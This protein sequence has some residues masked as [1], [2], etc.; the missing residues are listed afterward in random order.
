[1]CMLR[2]YAVYTQD[3]HFAT[4]LKRVTAAG[5][6]YEVHVARTRFWVDD[7]HPLH[8]WIALRCPCVDGETDHALGR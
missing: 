2:Q 1:M 5:F 4:V 3:P 8:S 6:D 7:E